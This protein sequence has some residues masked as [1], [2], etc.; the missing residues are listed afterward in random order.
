M[1]RVLSTNTLAALI[2]LAAAA[3]GRA[4]T[5]KTQPPPRP[6]GPPVAVDQGRLAGG[7]YSNDFFGL[8]FGVKEGWVAMDAATRKKMMDAGRAVLEDGLAQKKREQMDAAMARTVFL[9]SV[10]K[11]D[12]NT[13]SPEFNALLMCMAERVPTAVIKTGPDYVA[14]SLRALN[15]T[16]AKAELVGRVRAETLGGAPFTVADIK[17]MAGPRTVAQR[18]YVRLVKGYALVFVYTYVDEADLPALEEM[19][20]TVRFK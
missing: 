20:K 13:P 16:A 5:G 15:E 17:L 1:K 6:P 11:Y 8:S 4:Q 10:S 19:I 12:V 9:I 7:I 18:Y 14:T 2:L 3:A